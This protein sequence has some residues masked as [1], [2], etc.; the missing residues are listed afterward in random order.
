VFARAFLKR[1]IGSNLSL[2]TRIGAIRQNFKAVMFGQIFEEFMKTYKI[3]G[4]EYSINS[5]PIKI[6]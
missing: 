2:R 6:I 3:S 5:Y 1:P 4:D